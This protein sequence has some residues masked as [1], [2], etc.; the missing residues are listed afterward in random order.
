MPEEKR[1]YIVFRR[2]GLIVYTKPIT[3][4]E[5]EWLYREAYNKFKR[6][7]VKARYLGQWGSVL[8][9]ANAVGV[10]HGD[11][12][13]WRWG[14]DK[15]L[16]GVYADKGELASKISKIAE[17]AD[18]T[19]LRRE[20]RKLAR[21]LDELLQRPPE[22]KRLERRPR[23][24]PPALRYAEWQT[25]HVRRHK[26]DKEERVSP[27]PEWYAYRAEDSDGYYMHGISVFRDSFWL[28]RQG[29]TF[30]EAV[31]VRRGASPKELLAAL[32]D[33]PEAAEF[34]WR[35]AGDFARLADEAREDMERRGLSDVADV[36]KK[37][38]GL[39]AIVAGG[40]RGEEE[41]G[42]PA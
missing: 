6:I 35:H 2:E 11:E 27:R 3:R 38:L 23:E 36:A 30:T 40:R 13:L 29:H 42:V 19:T 39:S 15:E 37:V 28:W 24:P 5:A 32:V 7:E 1:S 20:L 8:N 16:A 9:V 22:P 41:E 14:L 17:D 12:W 33:D 21:A 4:E 18:S 25:R 31:I 26:W 34:L 10:K